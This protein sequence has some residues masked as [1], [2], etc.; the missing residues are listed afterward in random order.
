LFS[1]GEAR[2]HLE[3]KMN[4]NKNELTTNDVKWNEVNE[5][6]F[7]S[8]PTGTNTSIS[9]DLE[10]NA[11]P[12]SPKPSEEH[13]ENQPTDQDSSLSSINPL[14]PEVLKSQSC[15]EEQ[16]S[17]PKPNENVQT[18]Q[19]STRKGTGPRT[20]Q[21]KRR[22]K[23]NARKHGLFFKEV[24]LPGEETSEYLAR[25]EA[26]RDD[27]KPQGPSQSIEV[28]NL[29]ISDWHERRFLQ[30][31]IAA[32]SENI[33]VTEFDATAKRFAE[34]WNGSR[35]GLGPDGW[36]KDCNNPLVVRQAKDLL[37]MFREIVIT[38][39]F[40]QD[41]K[42]LRK[43]YGVEG[44]IPAGFSLRFEIWSMTATAL[45]KDGN[46]LS[47][48]KFKSLMIKDLDGE[49]ERVT[50]LEKRLLA[51]DAQRLAYKLSAAVIPGQEVLDRLLRYHTHFSRERDRILTRLERLQR[52]RKGE[53]PPLH[54][55]VNIL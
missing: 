16:G 44:G 46:T 38:S 5:E 40:K 52:M 50:E 33:A 20:A 48:D 51:I 26:L 4:S 47:C 11:A 23:L 3:A 36:L 10:K 19:L 25:L 13:V 49:I 17:A 32:I 8:T 42:V 45:E 15:E 18:G 21:G 28:E 24:L 22:S 41:S 9:S 1:A 37:K 7:S 43:L 39:G 12:E 2:L 53:P 27:H 30:A 31:E 54:I 55:N 29:A 6:K 14:Q 34:T 35:S